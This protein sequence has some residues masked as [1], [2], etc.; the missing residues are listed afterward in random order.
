MRAREIPVVAVQHGIIHPW[1][2]GYILPT[3]DGVSLPARTHV[4]GEY[5]ARLLTGSSVY[6]PDE[7]VVS[8][9]PHAS[10]YVPEA[11]PDAAA[12]SA[13]REG[14]GVAPG[15]RLR[16]VLV[17]K[18]GV[19][20]GDDHRGGVRLDP[21]PTVARRSPRGELHPTEDDGHFYP[22]LIEGIARARGF[23][24]PA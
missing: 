19:G 12:R 23:S 8:G 22:E 5:E 13:V 4:F 20:P 11:R 16:G 6:R 7:V 24:P 2:P 18:L 1:H 17:D 15:E 14:L 21:R 10:I 3:R 9:A